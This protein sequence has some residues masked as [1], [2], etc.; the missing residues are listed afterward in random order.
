MIGLASDF[1]GT[2][3]HSEQKEAFLSCDLAAIQAFQ[4]EGN[5]FGICSGRPL[6]SILETTA[7][8]IAYDFYIVSS[9]A[10]ICD[11]NKNI[12]FQ[13]CISHQAMQKI[14]SL[15]HHQCH[16][17]I[18]ADNKSFTFQ[19]NNRM[20]VKKDILSSYDELLNAQI[21][22]ISMMCDDE[23]HAQ[24]VCEQL[25]RQFGADIEAFQ[26]L[27]YVD[28]V[29]KGCSKGAGMN[30]L[31]TQAQLSFLA[32]IGD[33]YNDEPMLKHADMAFTFHHAPKQI[34]CICDHLVDSVA[35]AIR[36]IEKLPR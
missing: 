7:D 2:L 26:N 25:R 28:I 21:Y 35:E 13:K 23:A 6:L 14:E 36:I 16:V 4:S 8:R 17:A 34:Q 29:A 27:H 20:P 5:L 22:G 9:G 19:H 31:K 12:L 1:D 32:G 15:Y 30:F 33:S 24:T 3:Y 11:K 18:Q 10:V